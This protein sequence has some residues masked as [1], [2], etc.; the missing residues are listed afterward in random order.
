MRH[1]LRVINQAIIS[2]RKEPSPV[3][4][5]NIFLFNDVKRVLKLI[6][7]VRVCLFNVAVVVIK[8]KQNQ[9][10]ELVFNN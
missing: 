2:G 9:T 1:G 3:T 6:C 5:P 4:C 7:F 8:S 10:M